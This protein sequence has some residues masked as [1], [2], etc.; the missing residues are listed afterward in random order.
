MHK[1]KTVRFAQ[2]I[3]CVFLYLLLATYQR[4]LAQTSDNWDGSVEQRVSGLIT[5]WS[6][7]KFNFPFF[8]QR[9]GLDWDG[10]MQEYLPRVIAAEGIE[11]YYD[12]LSEFGA[13][14]KDGH[15]GVN[16]PG[17][18][19]NP[20]NDWPPLEVQVIDERFIVV[21]LEETMELK[22]NRVYQGLEIFEVE[23]IPVGE[24]FQA[25][26]VRFESRG[27][28]HAD[29][30]IGIYKLL[31]GPKNSVVTLKVRDLDGTERSISLTRNSATTSGKA[32]FPRLLEW[33]LT[34][35]PVEFSRIDNG[36]VYIKIANFGSENVVS[37]FMGQFDQTNWDS[38]QG[39]ILDLRFNPGG[40]DQYAWPIISC[41]I[42][43][44]IKSPLWKSPKY[45]PA[46]IS[47]GFDPEWEQGFL[48]D[49]YI[50]PRA[51]KRFLGP[52]VILTGHSTFSTAEDF[53]IPL[54]YSHRA[55]LVGE[56]TAGS[57]GNPRRVPLPGGGD[58]RV[59][60]LRTTYP[61]GRE[62]VGTGI[63]PH[64]E[65]HQS[66]QDV[67]EGR[68]AILLKGIEVINDWDVSS[69]KMGPQSSAKVDK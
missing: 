38:V 13:L 9:P 27:A 11:D 31:Q 44:P 49:E 2:L 62:W 65:V 66:R 10:K 21:R 51:G 34:D 69:L 30:A 68:N 14:L 23:E 59:V 19:L 24:Y 29:E 57:T 58:F 67:V 16:R 47:W 64:L 1:L 56:T 48:G 36:I 42:S 20:A 35:S 50:Q 8:D 40:D 17:G 60:T 6:E 22:K 28:A 25:H 45:V 33:Y 39:V 7:A 5:V 52:L 3:I 46:K 32:F 55:L 61:D 12:V 4:A 15:T 53:I 54:D 63:R 26:V 43:D 18:P 41:F 37:D